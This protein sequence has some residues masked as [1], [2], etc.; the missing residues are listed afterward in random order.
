MNLINRIGNIS[1]KV[2][3]IGLE[4]ELCDISV[5]V[6]DVTPAEYIE[7]AKAKQEQI[8]EFTNLIKTASEL[9]APT[10]ASSGLPKGLSDLLKMKALE[11]SSLK[12]MFSTEEPKSSGASGFDLSDLLKKFGGVPMQSDGSLDV[13]KMLKDITKN[14]KASSGPSHP[15]SGADMLTS[16]FGPLSHFNGEDNNPFKLPK[17]N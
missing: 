12:D 13:A 2:K 11:K 5:E 9:F 6:V 8:K 14:G 16:L 15:I 10:Q 1:I 3:E 17:K 7:V 4:V